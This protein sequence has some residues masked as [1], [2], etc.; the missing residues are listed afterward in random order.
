MNKV[1]ELDIGVKLKS[2]LGSENLAE[3]NALSSKFG[4][5]LAADIQICDQNAEWTQVEEND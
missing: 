2:K 4:W 1:H 3:L 5:Q